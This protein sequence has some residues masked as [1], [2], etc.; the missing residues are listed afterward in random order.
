MR[1]VL[2]LKG[3]FLREQKFPEEESRWDLLRVEDWR[4]WG[5][6][7]VGGCDARDTV[8][9]DGTNVESGEGQIWMVLGYCSD[10]RVLDN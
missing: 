4:K 2:I 3:R 5:G 1:M 7:R 9:R 8:A 6:L 10:G